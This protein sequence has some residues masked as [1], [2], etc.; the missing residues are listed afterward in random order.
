MAD[1]FTGFNQSFIGLASL[2]DRMQ[3][4]KLAKDE[5]AARHKILELQGK[6]LELQFQEDQR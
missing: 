3:R 6:R 4:T 5:A 2:R 1:F